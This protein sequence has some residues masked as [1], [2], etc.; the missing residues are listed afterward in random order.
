MYR[1]SHV[2]IYR[3]PAADQQ[4]H[5]LSAGFLRPGIHHAQYDCQRHVLRGRGQ[6]RRHRGW[7]GHPNWAFPIF[8][9]TGVYS[10]IILAFRGGGDIH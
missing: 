5:A 8:V 7:R 1:E 4:L 10:G 9:E 2:G 6:G 3:I